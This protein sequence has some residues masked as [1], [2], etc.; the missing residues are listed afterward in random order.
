MNLDLLEISIDVGVEWLGVV[1]YLH[2]ILGLF[3][4]DEPLFLCVIANFCGL[5]CRVV[6]SHVETLGG[7][8]NLC[9]FESFRQHCGRRSAINS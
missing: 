9:D 1:G 8:L 3:F 4:K 6:H 7:H 2:L 5:V